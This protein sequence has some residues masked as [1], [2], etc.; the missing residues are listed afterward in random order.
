MRTGILREKDIFAALSYLFQDGEKKEG[1]E[2]QDER[3]PNM[4]H[5]VGEKEGIYIISLLKFAS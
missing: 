3:V 4:K 5:L 2:R 1:L